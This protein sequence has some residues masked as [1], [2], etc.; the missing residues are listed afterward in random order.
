MPNSLRLAKP[1]IADHTVAKEY[2]KTTPLN[3]KQRDD[4][5]TNSF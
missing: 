3:K 5:G 1:S 2:P 4:R